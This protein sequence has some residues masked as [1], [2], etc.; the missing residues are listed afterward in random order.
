MI[1]GTAREPLGILTIADVWT[2]LHRFTEAFV[3]IHEIELELRRLI[4]RHAAETETPLG[5]LLAAMH[6]QDGIT[7][8][9]PSVV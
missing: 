3:L 2:I 1:V 6:V 8:D 9:L 7:I 5:D 4:G